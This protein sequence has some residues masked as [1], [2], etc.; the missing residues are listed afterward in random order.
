MRIEKTEDHNVSPSHITLHQKSNKL[1]VGFVDGAVYEFAAEYLRVYSPSAEVRGHNAAQA[2]LQTG[3]EN[4]RI[5]SI[6]PVGQYA[7]KLCFSD[8]HN[9]GL[10]SW[11]YLYDLGLKHDTYW[12]D[13]LKALKSAGHTRESDT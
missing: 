12:P 5:D 10:Y 1:E 3:K 7:I 4:V 13:Y 6:E 2:V 9:T 8:G 11:K